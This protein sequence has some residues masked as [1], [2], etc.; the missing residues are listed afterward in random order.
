MVPNVRARET[1]HGMGATGIG[2]RL[3]QVVGLVTAL[4]WLVSYAVFLDGYTALTVVFG[5][6]NPVWFLG[7]LAY[8]LSPVV[9]VVLIAIA[10]WPRALAFLDRSNASALAARA[11]LVLVPLFW[12]GVVFVGGSAMMGELLA[13]PLGGTLALPVPGGAFFHVV[14]QHWFQ[15]LVAIALGFVPEEFATLTDADRPAG[16]QCAVVQCS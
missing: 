5:I 12:M 6:S 14:F 4:S 10:V 8:F 7:G 1:A 9:S 13:A 11:V 2:W 3:F 15:G 16:I